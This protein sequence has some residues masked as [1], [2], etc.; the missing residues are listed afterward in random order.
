MFLIVNEGIT[1]KQ[2]EEAKMIHVVMDWS[3]TVCILVSFN[4]DYMVTYRKTYRYVYI[5]WLVYTYIFPYF[6]N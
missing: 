4:I 5:K 3:W 2:G 1:D 6:F